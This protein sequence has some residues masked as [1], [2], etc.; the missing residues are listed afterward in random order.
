[1]TRPLSVA[2]AGL[3]TVGA[4]TLQILRTNAELIAARAGR[5]IAVTAVAARDRSRDRGIPL[6]GLRWYDDPVALAHDPAVDVV[7]EAIGGSEGAGTVVEVG[8]DVHRFREGDRVCGLVLARRP[9]YGFHAQ[10]TLVDADLLWRVPARL[11]LQQAAALPVDGGLAMHAVDAALRIAPG[12]AVL[13]LGASGGIGHM[14]LQFARLRGGRVLAVASHR[15]G[16]ALAERLGADMAGQA[17][18]GLGAADHSTDAVISHFS[19]IIWQLRVACFCTGSADIA[20]LAQ[21]RL[22]PPL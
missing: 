7:V 2:L 21:A 8:A 1:M 20:A 4:G 5:P 3:G 19:A 16:Q 22:L 18:A 15:D 14:A 11:P 12:D 10:F 9:G 17:A 6:D 13:V